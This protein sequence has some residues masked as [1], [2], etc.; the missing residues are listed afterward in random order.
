VA[1]LVGDELNVSHVTAVSC[2]VE[3]EIIGRGVPGLF[4]SDDLV[5]RDAT[6][7]LRLQYRQPFGL[8]EFLFGWLKAARY[9]GR[10]ARIHGWYRRSPAPYIEI[11]RVEML[12]GQG[13]NARC[14]H[15]WGTV[16]LGT[17]LVLLGLAMLVGLR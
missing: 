9:I 13:D 15:V 8:L 3:G 14:Y 11:Q 4:W 6:G 5:M 12:D 17:F 10:R 7:F 2:V 1:S 16:L